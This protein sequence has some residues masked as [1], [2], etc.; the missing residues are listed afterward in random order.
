MKFTKTQEK[1]DY[2]EQRRQEYP[3]NKD[4]TYV[5]YGAD[6]YNDDHLYLL[7]P[8]TET[9]IIKAQMSAAATTRPSPATTPLYDGYATIR[10]RGLTRSLSIR[11][12]ELEAAQQQ[13]DGEEVLQR[14]VATPAVGERKRTL[15]LRSDFGQQSPYRG[16]G[17]MDKTTSGSGSMSKSLYQPA[18]SGE[19]IY[20]SRGLAKPVKTPTIGDIEPLYASANT[21]SFRPLSDASSSS[22]GNASGSGCRDSVVGSSGSGSINVDYQS[23]KK[24]SRFSLDSLHSSNAAKTPDYTTADEDQIFLYT[25]PESPKRRLDSGIRNSYDESSDRGYSP[26]NK[27]SFEMQEYPVIRTPSEHSQSSN[28]LSKSRRVSNSSIQYKRIQSMGEYP[29]RPTTLMTS[30]FQ[31]S[32]SESPTYGVTA[33]SPISPTHCS[34]KPPPTP[35]RRESLYAKPKIYASPAKSPCRSPSLVPLETKPKIS[36]YQLPSPPQRSSSAEILERSYTSNSLVTLDQDE[37]LAVPSAMPVLQNPV[38]RRYHTLGHMRVQS[39]GS[40]L[41]R[42]PDSPMGS[43]MNMMSGTYY[44]G[45][46]SHSHHLYSNLHPNKSAGNIYASA[47][48][49]VEDLNKLAPEYMD[50]LDFKIGCQTTLRSKPII[51]WYEL[52]IRRDLKRQ[53]CPPI[54]SSMHTN[55]T[56][57]LSSARSTDNQVNIYIF[58]FYCFL[59]LRLQFSLSMFQIYFV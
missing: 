22:G 16:S 34:H 3:E 24:N 9:I 15:S 37:I 58:S 42:A 43:L 4:D 33:R 11:A 46:G 54:S 27:Q 12:K 56:Q 40:S 21:T 25:A 6:D 51:P 36:C 31:R 52:A 20:V 44:N 30:S 19:E 13:E 18:G 32:D 14:H 10:G 47:E 41:H 29:R 1:C 57:T 38:D 7:T 23:M 35:V 53:S 39:L 49:A 50:P 48:A 2:N 59:L 55:G 45:A 28:S 17:V 8:T 26:F 5:G